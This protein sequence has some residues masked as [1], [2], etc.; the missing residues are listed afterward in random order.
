[1][2][3]DDLSD[4]DFLDWWQVAPT[5]AE[6]EAQV[7]LDS[8]NAEAGRRAAQLADWRRRH[9]EAV[10]PDRIAL[11]LAHLEEQFRRI[12]DHGDPGVLRPPDGGVVHRR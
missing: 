2:N 9:P 4:A 6:V 10:C 1:L 3:P 7:R 12:N 11:A 8:A 5:Q